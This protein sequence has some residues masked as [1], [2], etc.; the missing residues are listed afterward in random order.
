[1]R[2]AHTLACPKSGDRLAWVEIAEDGAQTVI[3]HVAMPGREA[4]GSKR[5]R[6]PESKFADV[7]GV[8]SVTSACPKCG[9]RWSVDLAAVLHGEPQTLVRDTTD[10][11]D[12]GVSFDRKRHKGG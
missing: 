4:R 7:E 12:L 9:G 10:Y 3:V 8:L 6:F 5:V 1:M 11:R 2:R